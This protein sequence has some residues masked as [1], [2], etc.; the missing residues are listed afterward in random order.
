MQ[1]SNGFFIQFIRLAGPFWHSENK[2]TIRSLALALLM[3]TVM[4]IGIAVVI[5]IWSADLFNAL[6]QRS[7]SRLFTQI[8]LIV[9]IFAA[10]IAVTT[11]HFKVKRRL[12]L[13]WRSWLTHRLISQ[14]M[15]D[16]RHYLVT[17]IQGEGAHD[18]PDG[19]IAEDIRIATEAAIDLCHS[20]IYSVLLLISFTKILWTLSGT[21]TLDLLFFEI[22]IYGHLVWLAMFYAACASSL[23]W[24]LGRPYTLA[25]DARQTVEANFRFGLVSA[26]ENSLAIALVHGE[27]NERTRFIALFKDIVHAWQRQTHAW[28]HLFML[29]SGYSVLSMAFPI[30]VSAPR[31]ILG[32]ITLGALMQSAQAFQQAAGAMSWPVDNMAKVAEWRAS[33]ERV[34]GLVNGLSRL[35]QEIARYDPHR[36]ILKKTEQD[37]LRLCD[38]CIIRLDGVV[39][40]SSINTEIRP[41]ER[42]LITGN[43]FTGSKL[44]KAIVGLWPWG[45]GSIELP[46]EPVFF[47]PP[48]PYLPTGTLR[49]AICYP[50]THAEYTEAAIAEALELV[51]LEELKEQL[52]HEDNWAAALSREQQQR[53][54]VVRLLLQRPS[55][56]L[57]Q[58]AMD[59]LDSSW[60]MKMLRLI[61]QRLPEAAILTIT[62]EPM[63]EDFHQRRIAL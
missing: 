24:W 56:I 9:L 23:G 58:E 22:P 10:N 2:S 32:G 6:E 60:E 13:D 55:W 17:H 20:L 57:L 44:F 8:A 62:N 21:V 39:C 34:L 53:L 51:G 14:W 1:I 12:Q 59:S 54:G 33:V 19:R 4:Q 35:E 42:V 28:S 26:R 47:M 38:L 46:R 18:N 37:I 41:G 40:V 27:A 31:Y 5:T 25:T 11:A 16:G 43:A 45:E 50:S 61:A 30:L 48:R 3:L 52:D 49:A 15:T 36:I 7:M 29:T 63:A